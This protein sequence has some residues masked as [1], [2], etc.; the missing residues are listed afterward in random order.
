MFAFC[1][2]TNYKLQQLPSSQNVINNLN[3]NYFSPAIYY[4]A[5][6]N[7]NIKKKRNETNII[8]LFYKLKLKSKH[9]KK[10][11]DYDQIFKNLK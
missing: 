7:L 5:T 8:N 3:Q 9:T 4:N 1:N 10:Y 6:S 2:Q 11:I